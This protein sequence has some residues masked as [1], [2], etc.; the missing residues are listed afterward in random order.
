[1]LVFANS[2]GGHYKT[3]PQE[4]LCSILK[5]CIPQPQTSIFDQLEFRAMWID[6]AIL[7]TSHDALDFD[8]GRNVAIQG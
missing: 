2:I 3:V 4:A 7:K 6:K 5:G 1:M 8:P